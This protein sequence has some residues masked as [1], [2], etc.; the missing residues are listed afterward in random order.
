MV[1][2]GTRSSSTDG[3]S[4]A[5]RLK[6]CF[7]KCESQRWCARLACRGK[8]N[9]AKGMFPVQIRVLCWGAAF[10]NN[11]QLKNKRNGHL[12]PRPFTTAVRS[13]IK[14]V[15]WIFHSW[16]MD[17]SKLLNVF[18]VLAKK[19]LAEVL[20][21][22]QSSLKLLLRINL[23]KRGLIWEVLKKGEVRKK[24]KI[25]EKKWVGDGWEGDS[26]RTLRRK[27]TRFGFKLWKCTPRN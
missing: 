15:T 3:V 17:L 23:K 14:I 1:M 4:D 22:V 20:P 27:K 12:L 26:D 19:N 2:D 9:I 21:R 6:N 18:L 16:F 25:W 10:S 8:S 13:P 24:R 5:I 11:M 7:N